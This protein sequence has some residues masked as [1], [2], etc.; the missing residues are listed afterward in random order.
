MTA[1]T[2]RRLTH[3]AAVTVP[4]TRVSSLM[5]ALTRLTEDRGV[6]GDA[7]VEEVDITLLAGTRVTVRW[8][9][10]VDTEGTA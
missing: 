1:P 10:Y 5:D 8:F 3:R 2:K 7:V 9:E 6:P 4:L